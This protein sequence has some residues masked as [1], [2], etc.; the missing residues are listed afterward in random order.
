MII[1]DINI[2]YMYEDLDACPLVCA[3]VS[4]HIAN[5]ETYEKQKHFWN[6]TCKFIQFSYGNNCLLF[7]YIFRKH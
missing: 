7:L 2:G 3:F 4:R 5:T 6:Q 1:K